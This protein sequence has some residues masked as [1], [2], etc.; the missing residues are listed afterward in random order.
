[1]TIG[2]DINNSTYVYDS[3]LNETTEIAREVVSMESSGESSTITHAVL[4]EGLSG[5]TIQNVL[6]S[7]P[8]STI[9]TSVDNTS[10]T[11]CNA[12]L[13]GSISWDTSDA[14]LYLSSDKLFRFRYIVTDGSEPSRLVLEGYSDT[15]SDYLPKAEWTT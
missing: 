12:T 7:N 6:S 9:I 13:D 10:S 2:S 3:T 14:S 8:S 11:T 5:K 1:M 4:N 15:L